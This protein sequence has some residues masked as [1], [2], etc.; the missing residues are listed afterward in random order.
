MRRVIVFVMLVSA[1][2]TTAPKMSSA[3][4]TSSE[5]R[6]L[7]SRIE[8]LE[9][10]DALRR[11]RSGKRITRQKDIRNDLPKGVKR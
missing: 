5:I 4:G 10:R 6:E 3:D 8:K 2:C 9:N 7:R 11:F 1:G